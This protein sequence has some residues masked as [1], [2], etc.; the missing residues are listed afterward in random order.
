MKPQVC[1]TPVSLIDIYPTLQNLCGLQPPSHSPR[2]RRPDA[3]SPRDH[4]GSRPTGF[5]DIRPE[6]PTRSATAASAIP[7]IETAMR[8][9]TTTKPTRRSGPTSRQIRDLRRS[10]HGCGRFFRRPMPRRSNLRRARTPKTPT[11]GR[12][13]RSRNHETGDDP[14]GRSWPRGGLDQSIPAPQHFSVIPTHALSDTQLRRVARLALGSAAAP[15]WRCTPE[16][17]RRRN[18]AGSIGAG[19]GYQ[20]L[21]YRR[22]YGEA[23]SLLGNALAGVP[24]AEFQ[25]RHKFF[26]AGCKRPSD[27]P[28]RTAC[29][30]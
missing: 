8:N 3:D 11:R 24:R 29:L 22:D 26:P 4:R 21:R 20:L 18:Q 6:P 19:H 10:R 27:H 30:R 2:W 28:S 5:V 23:E 1:A 17:A 13:R 7:N 9:S 25:I 16:S 12:T 14:G 15:D